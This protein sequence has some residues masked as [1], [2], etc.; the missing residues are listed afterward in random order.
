MKKIFILF[1]F[2]YCYCQSYVIGDRIDTM[3]CNELSNEGSLISTVVYKIF[4]IFLYQNNIG[5]CDILSITFDF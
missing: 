2:L 3:C 5:Q 4:N 1:L